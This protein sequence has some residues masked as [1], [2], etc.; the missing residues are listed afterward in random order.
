MAGITHVVLVA[1]NGDGDELSRR[2][3]ELVDAHLP[4]IA[5]IAGVE[6]GTSVSTEGLEGDVDW[7]LVV[8]FDSREQAL[9]YLPHPEHQPVADFIGTNAA[10]V[11]VFD[12]AASNSGSGHR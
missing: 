3:S 11:T 12:I 5:G 1:W 7:G 6:R 10:R 9:A 2:A 8:R 4:G